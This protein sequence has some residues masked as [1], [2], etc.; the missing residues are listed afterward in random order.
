MHYF[1]EKYLSSFLNLFIVN[2]YILKDFF[3]AA[4]GLNEI[5]VELF[6]KVCF[7]VSFDVASVFSSI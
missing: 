6:D 2:K 1:V 4:N 3:D 5:P 7:F